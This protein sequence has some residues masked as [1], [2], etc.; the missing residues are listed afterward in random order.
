MGLFRSKD[1]TRPEPPS[2]TLPVPPE[3]GNR[4]LNNRNND[5]FR[6][7]NISSADTRINQVQNL[8]PGTTT[9]TTTTTTTSEYLKLDLFND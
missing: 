5:S 4:L 6:S 8:N 9:T 7:S 1:K 3:D 2:A